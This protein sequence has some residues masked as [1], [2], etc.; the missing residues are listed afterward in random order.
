MIPYMQ[1]QWQRTHASVAVATNYELLLA[2]HPLKARGIPE[3]QGR[4]QN[5]KNGSE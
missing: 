2:Q 5:T 1:L 4:C 3:N